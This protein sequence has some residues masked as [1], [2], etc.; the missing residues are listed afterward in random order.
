MDL[1][2]KGK[3]TV[4]ELAKYSAAVASLAGDYK[5]AVWTDAGRARGEDG[6]KLKDEDRLAVPAMTRLVPWGLG[7]DEAD[8]ACDE[9]KAIQWILEIRDRYSTANPYHNWRHAWDVYQ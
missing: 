8:L 6:G 3:I 7:V 5:A 9:A 1:H 4:G 2:S